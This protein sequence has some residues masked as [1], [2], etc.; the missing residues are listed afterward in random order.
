VES[1]TLP[2]GAYQ[3]NGESETSPRAQVRER[4][5]AHHS[6]SDILALVWRRVPLMILV[7]V[8]IVA[9]GAF[10][11]LQIQPIF[12]AH[13][14]LLIRLGQEY[15]YQPAV[16]DAARGA[17]PD[18][19]QVVQSEL[20]ILESE[21]V[22]RKT[23][24][25]I[26]V[27]RMSPAL[28]RAYADADDQVRRVIE[29]A[30]ERMIDAGLKLQTAP[31]SAIVKL[32]YT[33]KDPELAALVLN[34]LVDEYLRYRR[35]V[36]IDGEAGQVEA[37]LKDFQTRLD[38][39]DA[40]YQAFLSD[41]GVGSGDFDAEKAALTQI[42]AQ[43]TTEA[44]S[45]QASLSEAQ[46]RLGVTRTRAAQVQP[47]IG[48]YRDLDHQSQDELNKLLV[49]RQD[50]L[51]RY[52]PGAQPIRDIDQKI[53]ALQALI[54]RGP[55]DGGAR[56]IGPNPIYQ[57]LVTDRDQ[58]EAQVAS[59]RDRLAEV[60]ASLAEVAERRRKLAALEPQFQDLARQRDLLTANVKTLAQ[61]AQESQAAQA[62]AK[63]GQDNI[64]VVERAY[65]A[66]KGTSLKLPV[67][68]LSVLFAA[69]AAVCAGLI[70]AFTSKGYAT[71]ETVERTLNLPVLA[72]AP[73]RLA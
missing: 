65:P 10:I 68:V 64:R 25:D 58:L 26:G 13:S 72:S 53:V 12:A 60:R 54:A 71:S 56:R 20:E 2:E 57:S 36:L 48:L 22:K 66:V 46:G 42:Y 18:S 34:T 14:S 28:G 37:Q 29:A 3:T 39:A 38:A 23:V 43:L 4:F 52:L 69:F 47:E 24:E 67:M 41:N 6:P 45:N 51:S 44:Y 73:A 15:V 40:A 70:S 17:T 11:A 16:G 49:Q 30:A 21:A 50:L 61:R 32:S 33:A 63:S 8:V 19:D 9:A 27:A 5:A 55:V 59:Y 7:F 31:G 1:P 62:M 35:T